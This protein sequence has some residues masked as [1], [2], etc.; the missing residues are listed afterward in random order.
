MATH[1]QELLKN[2]YIYLEF[3]LAPSSLVKRNKSKKIDSL[4]LS[5]IDFIS[6]K[7]SSIESELATNYLNYFSK[8]LDA[9]QVKKLKD[10]ASVSESTNKKNSNNL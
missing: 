2:L 1:F 6:G 7:I 4:C 9:A 3:N 10:V 8:F 5:L